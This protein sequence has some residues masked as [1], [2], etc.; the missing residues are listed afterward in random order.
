MKS[1]AIANAKDAFARTARGKATQKRPSNHVSVLDE[2]TLVIHGEPP[3]GHRGLQDHHHPQAGEI[4]G[5][6]PRSS[7]AHHQRVRELMNAL[8]RW[9]SK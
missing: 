1:D 2:V 5:R 7:A 6:L 3:K 8:W 9:L 4:L